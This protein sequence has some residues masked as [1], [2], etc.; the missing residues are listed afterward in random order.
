MFLE[1]NIKSLNL[2]YEKKLKFTESDKIVKIKELE[3]YYLN[4]NP[5]I[6]ELLKSKFKLRFN[7]TDLWYIPKEGRTILINK[8]YKTEP[9]ISAT[10]MRK[11]ISI[12]INL[13]KE[14]ELRDSVLVCLNNHSDFFTAP[15]AIYHHHAY[16]W[17]LLEHTLQVLQN[18]LA[19]KLYEINIRKD[20]LIAGAILHD[21]GKIDCYTLTE[22]GV[23]VTDYISSQDHIV[24]GIIIVNNEIKSKYIDEIIHIVASH[25][26]KKEYG[27]PVEPN[28]IEAKIINIA[29]KLSAS[30]LG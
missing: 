5:E 1:K 19:F 25:H 7:K 11:K 20:I 29:D 10:N 9:S 21:I 4:N 12:Y 23:D 13:I 6:K 22:T 26:G 16:R 17:G 18:S 2:K 14:K 15:A 24:R 8:L 3:N 30:L 28:T 27:S